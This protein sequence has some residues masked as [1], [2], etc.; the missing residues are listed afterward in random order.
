[1]AVA[2]VHGGKVVFA[3]GYGVREVGK[4]DLVDENTVFQ[5]ASVSKS[6]GSTV[7]AHAVSDGIVKW[8]DPVVKYLPT[9]SCPTRP[10]PRW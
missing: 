7:V 10:S 8:S 2:V 4:P 3:K 5:L 6:I 1:M 9:S